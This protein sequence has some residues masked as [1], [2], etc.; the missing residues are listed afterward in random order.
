MY[1]ALLSFQLI[2][3]S[4]PSQCANEN[5]LKREGYQPVSCEV[6]RERASCERASREK[7]VLLACSR[8]K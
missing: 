3:Y 2:Y 7:G 5:R 4:L 6:T 8:G 1:R